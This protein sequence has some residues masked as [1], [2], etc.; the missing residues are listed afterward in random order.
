METNPFKLEEQLWTPQ[1]VY[2]VSPPRELDFSSFGFLQGT[3]N[4]DQE[5]T[6]GSL[7]KGTTS[8]LGAI[9]ETLGKVVGGAVEFGTGIFKAVA[10]GVTSFL[11]WIGQA[12]GSIF[13]KP[14]VPGM[15]P[16]FNPIKTN[17]E[18]ALRPHL[19]KVRDNDK[20]IREAMEKQAKIL[21]ESKALDTRI[22]AALEKISESDERFEQQQKRFDYLVSDLRNVYAHMRE[23]TQKSEEI[24]EQFERF[25]GELDLLR[26]TQALA[27]QD[28]QRSLQAT[29]DLNKKI[30]QRIEA[31]NLLHAEAAKATAKVREDLAEAN[32]TIGELSKANAKMRNDV[33]EATASA[34]E[35]GTAAQANG[36][37]LREM[38]ANMTDL[39]TR[40]TEEVSGVEHRAGQALEQQAQNFNE[41]IKKLTDEINDN[42]DQAKLAHDVMVELTKEGGALREDLDKRV[43]DAITKNP[44]LA[45]AATNAEEAA[46]Q[47][48][49]LTGEDG[50]ITQLQTNAILANQVVGKTNTKAIDILTGA[51]DAQQVLNR[52]QEKWNEASEAATTAN[53]RAIEAQA[54][55]SQLLF[56]GVNLTPG[57]GGKPTAFTGTPTA[58]E[59][60]INTTAYPLPVS[61]LD[62]NT[63]AYTSLT[64]DDYFAIAKGVDLRVRF[65]VKFDE[66]AA[67]TAVTLRLYGRK[68]WT[69]EDGKEAITH[70][71]GL[72]TF[73]DGDRETTL[74]EEYWKPAR[75]ITATGK[76]G[77]WVH[78]DHVIKV[79]ET[80]DEVRLQVNLNTN[81]P[82]EFA[83]PFIG[84]F[85]PIQELVDRTQEIAI[86]NLRNQNEL[87]AE[88]HRQ[89]QKWNE[90]AEQ[91]MGLNTQMGLANTR[92]IKA[93][94]RID[95]GASLVLYEDL[96]DEEI[97]DKDN[98]RTRVYKP[99]WATAASY[100]VD[101][102]ADGYKN[103]P[104][105]QDIWAAY[106][107]V[108]ETRCNPNYA[109]V[110]PNAVYKLSFYA[111]ADKP[112]SKIYIQM[113]SPAGEPHNS[114]IPLTRTV[115]NDTGER[116]WKEGAA[117]SYAVSALE[118]PVG[119][120]Q[121]FEYRVR[122]AEEVSAISFGKI[123]WNHSSG[124]KATQ[125]IGDLEFSLDVPTQ[126]DVDRAQNR[127]IESLQ[128][129]AELSR[130]FR[131]E[132]IRINE[133]SS[134]VNKAQTAAIR[135]HSRA[136]NTS[137]LIQYKDLTN[138]EIFDKG[139]TTVYQPYWTTAF[140]KRVDDKKT[141]DGC[142][143]P[144]AWMVPSGTLG[145]REAERGW[146]GVESGKEYKLSFWAKSS[147]NDSSMYIQMFPKSGEPYYAFRKVLSGNKSGDQ[148]L[149]GPDTY[150]ANDIRLT[151]KWQ[152]FEQVIRIEDGVKN[153]AF[154]RFYFNHDRGSKK[155][156]QYVAGVEFGLN[157]PSQVEIDTAQN[158]ALKALN[159]Q[160]QAAAQLDEIQNKM[161]LKNQVMTGENRTAIQGIEDGIAAF[162]AAKDLDEAWKLEQDRN[163][164]N[165]RSS[166]EALERALE[167]TAEYIPRVLFRPA[168]TEAFDDYIHVDSNGRIMAKGKWGGHAIIDAW[169]TRQQG[170][171]GD[172]LWITVRDGFSTQVSTNRQL[173][174]GRGYEKH[175]MII[176]YHVYQGTPVA[177]DF[178]FPAGHGYIT[179]S[180]YKQ[181]VFVEVGRVKTYPVN[182]S[183]YV[184][185][186]TELS[187][188]DRECYYHLRLLIDGH[189]VDNVQWHRIGPL[190]P[191]GNGRYDLNRLWTVKV[192]QGRPVDV[193]VE[194]GFDPGQGDGPSQARAIRHT[195]HVRYVR[196]PEQ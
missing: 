144:E 186:T 20:Q 113:F 178:T 152:K 129:N 158:N 173:H 95:T 34:I 70:T 86:R 147:V 32:S 188:A 56:P 44:E 175:D 90:V 46:R 23:V 130:D 116:A 155:G 124:A 181:G 28:I 103:N 5:A 114:L 15:P 50:A 1:P 182:G 19:D 166:I 189:E 125:Y 2:D 168:N 57:R 43:A 159:E 80:V 92:A 107:N 177:Q 150:I 75:Y 47:L 61:K 121:K 41:Q 38:Q 49:E 127:A 176:N 54:A 194:A 25:E 164:E 126:A 4:F 172:Y 141:M 60:L 91:T 117:T 59:K 81:S 112:G 96:T 37:K 93:L 180:T 134:A 89:Q 184:S 51:F 87:S 42:I 63:N 163:N 83:G 169:N 17:L 122:I 153:L 69:K 120:M 99:S 22:D 45:A 72:S 157:T 100:R 106:P 131:A 160:A 66:N 161:I 77:V 33:A 193:V 6:R 62:G 76:K 30:D 111:S 135:A 109:K 78:F 137:S 110:E 71:K 14:I 196:G 64:P 9:M 138:E 16:I 140:T 119:K 149:G 12:L 98:P 53:S 192:D 7:E 102:N 133:M 191:S 68:R 65:A 195:G 156:D 8:F 3:D 85:A 36:T 97:L 115:N 88:L 84:P 94:A 145:M 118:L 105:V 136:T 58:G 132:Q 154:A 108:G 11:G 73:T 187:A 26:D 179:G 171:Q 13:G 123:C 139:L 39:S 35:A 48:K 143:F 67:S 128:K 82:A 170:F 146:M 40:L 55:L 10:D 142:P 148:L 29:E 74:L 24:V 162:K 18:E 31:Q 183:L 185:W 21:E 165:F 101:K 27:K 174:T 190:F 104:D 52:N 79:D 151:T 167:K